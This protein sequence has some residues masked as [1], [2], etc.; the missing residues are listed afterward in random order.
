MSRR[1]WSIVEKTPPISRSGRYKFT[2]IDR[3]INC[4]IY[5]LLIG[6]STLAA[7][8]KIIFGATCSWWVGRRIAVVLFRALASRG[9]EKAS[10]LL[11]WLSI[12]DRLPASKCRVRARGLLLCIWRALHQRLCWFRSRTRSVVSSLFV[13]WGCGLVPGI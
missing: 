13:F 5:D 4:K 6:S 7:P 2:L 10:E 11:T 1:E 3:I 8:C 12:G 9:L